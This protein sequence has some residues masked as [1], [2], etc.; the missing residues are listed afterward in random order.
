MISW[1]I[2]A[3]EELMEPS[4]SAFKRALLGSNRHHSFL[5]L[6]DD[7]TGNT[8]KEIHFSGVAA[9]GRPTPAA[10]ILNIVAAPLD[11]ARLLSVF[12]KAA[13]KTKAGRHLVRIKGI[14]TSGRRDLQ[15]M[16]AVQR[17]FHGSPS[18]ALRRWN[19]ACEAIVELNARDI[20]FLTKSVRKPAINC[21]A[22][23]E[24]AL[25]SMGL[26]SSAALIPHD[27]VGAGRNLHRH[28]GAS[29]AHSPGSLP[30][31][32]TQNKALGESIYATRPQ[33][34]YRPSNRQPH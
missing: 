6:V 29:P 11:K 19:A 15:D 32:L 20:P 16:A 12:A 27:T 5:M 9:D 3:V 8:L 4:S 31:L 17:C 34:R 1:S 10:K 14:Q 24:F 23:T 22:G 18:D 13:D 33:A 30:D 26:P 2:Y 25:A 7:A 28:I 21:R